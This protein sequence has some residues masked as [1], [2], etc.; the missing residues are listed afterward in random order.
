MLLSK[1]TLPNAASRFVQHR[2]SIRRRCLPADAVVYDYIDAYAKFLCAGEGA[3]C[4]KNMIL[5][6]PDEQAR[7]I[8]ALFDVKT[9]V[10]T[11][12]LD[13]VFMKLIIMHDTDAVDTLVESLQVY[14]SMNELIRSIISYSR[15]IP[16]MLAPEINI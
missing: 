11:H 1:K 5:P 10:D 4:I 6:P 9:R 7:V 14:I 8:H 3:D 16:I 13:G 12:G 2:T 15:E